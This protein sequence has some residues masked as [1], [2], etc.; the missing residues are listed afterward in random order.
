MKE[1]L[2]EI[3]HDGQK[4]LVNLEKATQLGLITKGKTKRGLSIKDIPNGSIFR[5]KHEKYEKMMMNNK[6]KGDGQFISLNDWNKGK[7]GGY[8]SFY[9]DEVFQ[10]W[11]PTNEKW[12]SEIEEG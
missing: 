10:Y 6:K 12:I 8:D 3:T 11:D 9:H 2:I 4:Y 7:T 1:N 5:Y